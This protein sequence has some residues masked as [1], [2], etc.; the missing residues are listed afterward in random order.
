M[1]S[2]RFTRWLSAKYEPSGLEKNECWLRGAQN[3]SRHTMAMLPFKPALDAAYC[4]AVSGTRIKTNLKTNDKSVKEGFGLINSWK[5]P[6]FSLSTK[7]DRSIKEYDHNGVKITI[8]PSVLGLATIH[9]KDILGEWQRS[10][11]DSRSASQER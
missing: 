10:P 3:P 6:I 5:H 4:R 8:T 7:P 11:K 9:D 2:V 1:R